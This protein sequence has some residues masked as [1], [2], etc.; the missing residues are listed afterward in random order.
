[1]DVYTFTDHRGQLCNE[2]KQGLLSPRANK[3]NL[4]VQ[5]LVPVIKLIR[6]SLGLMRPNRL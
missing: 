2:E 3:L 4:C 6:T 1:M 5:L